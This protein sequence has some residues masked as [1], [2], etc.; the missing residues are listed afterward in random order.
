MERWRRLPVGLFFTEE[1]FQHEKQE[2]E[3]EKQGKQR[4]I[5]NRL[6][7]ALHYDAA[8]AG[9]VAFDERPDRGEVIDG[10]WG[11]ADRGHPR[12]RRFASSWLTVWPASA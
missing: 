3:T 7:Q 8:V 10:L 5:D 6:E 2:A 1:V 11:L 9:R 4:R 12:T